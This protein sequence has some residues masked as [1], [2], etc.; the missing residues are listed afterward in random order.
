MCM[1]FLPV[2]R[3]KRLFGCASRRKKDT[4]FRF[5]WKGSQHS[6]VETRVL[7]GLVPSPFLLVG[8]IPCHPKF[9]EAC[10]PDL[11]AELRKS[12]Y[13]NDLISGKPTVKGGAAPK[14]GSHRHIRG[15]MRSL[16]YISGTQML[17]S[18]RKVNQELKKK[19]G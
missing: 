17:P 14:T 13:L 11:V 3:N 18:W 19:L 12:L 4:L 10:I 8:V 15:S 5:H 9:W 1:R 16:H 2:A 7:F 6:E